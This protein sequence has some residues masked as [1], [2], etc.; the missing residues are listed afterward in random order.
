[1]TPAKVPM[2]AVLE[3]YAEG[4][5]VGGE[6]RDAR[7]ARRL[8]VHTKQVWRAM[9]KAYYEGYIDFGVTMR[10]GWLSPSGE[11]ELDRMRKE[12]A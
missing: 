4:F 8:G 3:A 11:A 1:M 5:I 2:R 12:E 7:I 9:E 10:S 6:M